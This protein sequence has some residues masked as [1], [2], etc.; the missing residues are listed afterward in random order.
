MIWVK[1]IGFICLNS[2]V[3]HQKVADSKN[4]E[5]RVQPT[6]SP[7]AYTSYKCLQNAHKFKISPKEPRR[8]TLDPANIYQR[9]WIFVSEYQ[10]Q[11]HPVKGRTLNEFA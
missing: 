7:T 4:R 10:Y 1:V 9:R 3:Q 11:I 5:T 2:E 8:I 6:V